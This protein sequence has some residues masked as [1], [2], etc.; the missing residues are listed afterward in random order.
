MVSIDLSDA[1]HSIPIHDSSKKFVCFEFNNCRYCFNVLPFGLSSAPRIFSKILRPA[2]SHLRSLGIKITS[3]LDDI[4]IIASCPNSLSRHTSLAI[5]L[6]SSLGFSINYS[7]SNLLPVRSLIHFGFLWNTLDFTISVPCDKVTQ[8]RNFANYLLSSVVSIRVA[9]SF[10]G[11]LVSTMVGYPYAPLHYRY[12]QLCLIRHRQTFSSWEDRFTPDSDCY[13]DIKWWSKCPSLLPSSSLESFTYSITLF[14]DASS[15]GWGAYLC[16]GLSSSGI[17][18]SDDSSHINLRE[19][20]AVLLGVSSLLPHIKG[21][22][23]RVL[24]DNIAT[25]YYI[26]KLGGTHSLPL[27]STALSLW[28]LFLDN[29]ISCQAFHIAGINNFNADELSRRYLHSELQLSH[30]AFDKLC[31]LIPFPLSYDLFASRYSRKLPCFA[32]RYQDPLAWK[33]DAFSFVWPNNCYIFPPINLIPR[34]LRK[35]K[36]DNV[37]YGLLLTPAWQTLSSLPMIIDLLCFYPIFVPSSFVEG[38]FPTRRPFN[39]MAWSISSLSAT[40][41]DFLK[42]PL[43]PSSKVLTPIPSRLTPTI[44]KSFTVGFQGEKIPI[45]YLDT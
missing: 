35:F 17:W 36:C 33:V 25:V 23:L 3:Y 13:A 7:K 41:K 42:R 28:N 4:L 26:N 40:R 45:I 10:L 2:I 6:L 11:T 29:G 38:E 5:D 24:S 16:N 1:F 15:H 20:K 22:S 18:S 44:G 12:F 31:S 37:E 43:P 14:T 27:C 32:S 39:L 21:K 19:L 30:V 8:I 34:I 9:S